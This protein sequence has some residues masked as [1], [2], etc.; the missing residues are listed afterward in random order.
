MTNEWRACLL[1]P[2][3]SWGDIECS[4]SKV[5]PE[6]FATGKEALAFAIRRLETRPDAIGATAKRVRQVG[7]SATN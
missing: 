1:V 2:T 6:R 3:A 5:L 7:D 4:R